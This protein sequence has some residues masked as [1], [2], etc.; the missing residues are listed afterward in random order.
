MIRVS[1]TALSSGGSDTHT[2]PAHTLTIAEIPSHDHPVY[3]G[4]GAGVY[5]IIGDAD[6]NRSDYTDT[7]GSTGGGGGHTH[8][9]ASNVPAYMTTKMFLKS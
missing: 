3:N 5:H 8:D 2:T 1:A 7:T 9:A 4:A 6:G